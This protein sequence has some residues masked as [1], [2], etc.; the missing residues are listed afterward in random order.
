MGGVRERL[1][2]RAGAT[3]VLGCGLLWSAGVSAVRSQPF[4]GVSAVLTSL[5]AIWLIGLGVRTHRPAR[6]RVWTL[7]RLAFLTGVV[8]TVLGVAFPPGDGVT[9][10]LDVIL[11]VNYLLFVAALVMVMPLRDGGRDWVGILDTLTLVIAGGT[12]VWY[13]VAEPQLRAGLSLHS[14]M[15]GIVFPILDLAL[16]VVLAQLSFVETRQGFTLRMVQLA[17]VGSVVADVG[18]ALQSP[19]DGYSLGFWTDGLWL[20]PAVGLAA[21]ALDPGTRTFAA[22]S[23]ADDGLVRISPARTFVVGAGTFGVLIGVAVLAYHQDRLMTVAPVMIGAAAVMTMVTFA[24]S[25][26]MVRFMKRAADGYRSLS[27]DLELA[28]REQERLHRQVAHVALHDEL[29]G[30][31]N[32]RLFQETLAHAASLDQPHAVVFVD[33]D[34]FKDVNDSLGHDVGDLVLRTVAR[35]LSGAVRPRDVVA[36]LGGDEFA[37]LVGGVARDHLGE[38][39]QRLESTVERPVDVAGQRIPVSFSAGVAWSGGRS[40]PAEL[41]RDADIAM[42]EAKRRGKNRFVVFEGWMRDARLASVERALG[43][44]ALHD[45]GTG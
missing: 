40:V 4:S 35:R 17:I 42:Y 15:V 3:V 38:V 33:L 7:V 1:P 43:T 12:V 39:A 16:L 20:L 19:P 25:A 28:L 21:A 44:D 23:D 6:R 29:T 22:H 14:V 5:V 18:T 8:A 11:L 30:L 24:R 9:A 41:L 26:E 27:D 32:R 2:T 31:A 34:D 45:A 37:I 13:F 36:R 10:A